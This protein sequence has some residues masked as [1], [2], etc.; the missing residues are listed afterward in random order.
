M[1]CC[2]LELPSSDQSLSGAQHQ[3]QART[4]LVL[5]HAAK[6]NLRALLNAEHQTLSVLEKIRIAMD[7]SEGMRFLH[8]WD[9]YHRDLK[10]IYVLIDAD[11]RAKL[12][13][14]GGGDEEEGWIDAS[15]AHHGKPSL[16]AVSA[17]SRSNKMSVDSM[18][19][20][21]QRRQADITAFGVILWELITGKVPNLTGDGKSKQKKKKNHSS[22]R[23]TNNLSLTEEDMKP[24]P[25]KLTRLMQQINNNS[26]ANGGESSENYVN[27]FHYI[28]DSVNEIC[29]KEKRRMEDRA[30]A[31]P[32]GFLCPIT[33]DVMRDPV[34]LQDGHSYERK[35]IVDWLKRSNR[36][37]LTNEELPMSSKD[38]S[39]PMMLDNYALKSAIS[40]SLQGKDT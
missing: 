11:N 31:V 1:G 33:Q 3:L 4:A 30:R 14:F 25:L 13:G 34:I 40:S 28:Y 7:V 22:M 32:D 35:A 5:E 23:V 36:S 20:K 15:K 8:S 10:S 21:Q 17:P 12:T 29:L 19:E 27:D 39:L 38:G 37:P 26:H 16:S 2:H 6:G 9:L 18:E 24:Y